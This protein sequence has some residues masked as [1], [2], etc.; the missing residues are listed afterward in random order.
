[1]VALRFYIVRHGETDANRQQIIQGQLDTELNKLGQEQ[2]DLVAERL[3]SIPFDVALASDLIRA[4]RTAE[5]IVAHHQSVTLVK[6]TDLRERFMGDLQ[7]RQFTPG[8]RW[9]STADGTAESSQA[10]I[11]RIN[12]W[13]D[14]CVLELAERPPKADGT[15]HEILVVSHG[16]FIGM[17]VRSLIRQQRLSCAKGV[18][19][20]ACG[21]TSVSIVEVE[22]DGKSIVTVFGDCSHL[23]EMSSADNADDEMNLRN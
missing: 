4:S 2:A 3:R 22:A 1:M 21:N 11:E 20:G 6:Q 19:V 15:P 12:E 10:F 5:T 14:T 7:G 17:L 18:I 8:S 9:A 13:W 23:Y 16:G